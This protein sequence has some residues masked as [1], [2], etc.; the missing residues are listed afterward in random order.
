MHQSFKMFVE[1]KSLND[2]N[3]NKICILYGMIKKSSRI[4]NSIH[5]FIIPVN[6]WLSCLEL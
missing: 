2:L 5:M 1:S 6:T 3:V 4:S